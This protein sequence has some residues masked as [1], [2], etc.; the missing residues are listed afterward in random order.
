MKI[1]KEFKIGIFTIIVIAIAY[2]GI[3]FLKGVDVLST[4]NTYYA[5]YDKSDGIEISSPVVIRGIS[6]GSVVDISIEGVDSKVKVALRVEKKYK[7]PTD[8]EATITSAS[9]MGGKIVDIGVGKSSQYLDNGDEIKG[10]LDTG[11]TDQIEELKET[12][13]EVIAD[14]TT[15]L[16][17]VNALLSP[18]NVANLSAT[19]ENLNGSTKSLENLL[20]GGEIN[21]M[22]SNLE[23]VT[24]ELK[25][26][27]PSLAATI[28]NLDD[29]TS[30]VN[31][32]DVGE[33]IASA[34]QTIAELNK[35]LEQINSGEGSIG[36]LLYRDEVYDN[37]NSTTENLSNLFLDLKEN[38]KRYVHFSVFG[39]KDK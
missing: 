5:Y 22:L 30:S 10:L 1:K 15:T 14:L 27:A 6:I 35:A 34:N 38:P 32:A 21:N 9:L 11:M 36:S 17:S 20:N 12:M 28:K 4:G 23:S 3:N 18:E 13:T 37:L 26:A 39:R 33:T 19:F 31:K 7:I 16:E 2:W 29:I 25:D 24:S 8:S